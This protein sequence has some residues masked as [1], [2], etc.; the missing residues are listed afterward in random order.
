MKNPNTIEDGLDAIRIK[1]YEETKN[2]TSDE[3]I[4][5]INDIAEQTLKNHGM[6][7]IGATKEKPRTVHG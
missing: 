1:L 7:I 4:A 5:Y 2:M 6:E 3:R